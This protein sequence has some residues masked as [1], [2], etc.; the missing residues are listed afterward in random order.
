MEKH[1]HDLEKYVC[2]F[3]NQI[4][5][6]LGKK[7]KKRYLWSHFQKKDIVNMYSEMEDRYFQHK[8]LSFYKREILIDE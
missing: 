3:G 1:K 2:I 8:A 4:P 6:W 7:I 5:V